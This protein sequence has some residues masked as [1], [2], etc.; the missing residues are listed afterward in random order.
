VNAPNYLCHLKFYILLHIVACNQR[1]IAIMRAS[2]CKRVVVYGKKRQLLLYAVPSWY[3]FIASTLPLKCVH[4]D[5]E[6]K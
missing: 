2:S 4:E 1:F 6:A 3:Q 5:G